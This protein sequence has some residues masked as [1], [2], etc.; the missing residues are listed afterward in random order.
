MKRRLDMDRIA[1]GLGAK[2]RGKVDA[3]D[4]YFGAM[5]LVAEV[6]ARFRVPSSGG[7]ATNPEW[8]MKRLVGL[9]PET[10]G[11]LEELAR[12]ASEAGDTP[13]EPMQLAAL[14]LEKA[15][16]KATGHRMKKAS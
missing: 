12:L 11:R 6:Q 5:Q 15:V 4:G 10:L 8:S 16:A 14:L 9:S 7:R 13:I 3:G 1:T 2:R